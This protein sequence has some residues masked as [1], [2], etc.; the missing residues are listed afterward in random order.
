[1]TT[2]S[3]FSQIAEQMLHDTTRIHQ[4]QRLPTD[5][6]YQSVM[7]IDCKHKL[8]IFKNVEV[9]ILQVTRLDASV[10][11]IRKRMD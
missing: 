4:E 7:P 8:H 9:N 11:L 10:E 5:F 2:R 3:D 6:V 1:M